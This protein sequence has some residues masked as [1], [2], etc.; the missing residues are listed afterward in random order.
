M[1]SLV[2]TYLLS[3]EK[4]DITVLEIPVHYTVVWQYNMDKNTLSKYHHK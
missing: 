2:S 3:K 4:I 1:L